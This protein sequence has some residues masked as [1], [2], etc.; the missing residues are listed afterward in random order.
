MDRQVHDSSG[1]KQ[2]AYAFPAVPTIVKTLSLVEREMWPFSM[3]DLE[4]NVCSYIIMHTHGNI[5]I[6]YY[7][8]YLAQDNCVTSLVVVVHLKL[9]ETKNQCIHW[10]FLPVSIMLE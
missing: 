3:T 4:S 2:T 8:T 7:L 6:Y 1:N 10:S 9:E 5:K